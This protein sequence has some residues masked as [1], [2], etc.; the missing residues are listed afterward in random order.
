MLLDI[1]KGEALLAVLETGSFEAA[2]MRLHLTPSAVSQ[3]VRALEEALGT[4]L[5]V[6]S[7]PCHATTAGQ[8]LAQYLRRSRLLEEEFLAEQVSNQQAPLSLPIVVN[9]DT[10]ATWLLPA[11]RDFL[12]REQVLLDLTVDD[13][14]H[15]YTWL[16]AGHVLAGVS[17]EPRAMRGCVAEPLGAMRY[18][19]LATPAFAARYF[20]QGLNRAA[21][22]LAPLLVF[23]RKDALQADF[24]QH[25]LGLAPGSYPCHYVPASD[26]FL[27]AIRL[28]LAYGM[29]PE[30][31]YGD[32]L[33]RG[34]LLDLAPEQPTDVALYWH[35]WQVQSPKLERLSQEVLRAARQ[36]LRPLP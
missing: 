24:L 2:A 26:A 9:S 12:L 7:R 14:D 15:T 17:S 31:Q 13:Q 16:E 1:R 34:E 11:L 27:L 4:P 20:P 28:G 18:R 21:A 36:H 5:L 6:R 8:R 22:R 23:N 32:A 3:R 10:L 33:A 25:Q 19:L 29:V 30:Q 35:R